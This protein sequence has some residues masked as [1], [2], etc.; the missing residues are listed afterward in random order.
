MK[1]FKKERSD[2]VIETTLSGKIWKP[3]IEDFKKNNYHITVF[4]IYLDTPEE[5][6]KRIGVRI[7]KE[8]HYVS[9][10]VVYR[11][12]V[13]SIRNFWFVY[14]NLANTWILINNSR[15]TPFLVAY[16]GGKNYTIIDEENFKRFLS[17]AR[18]KEG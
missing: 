9:K 17:I 1:K 12:Y 15:D 13:R 18:K 8:G 6:V 5:A 2:F 11:R 7:N 10:D 14:R 4:F 3:I 16:G